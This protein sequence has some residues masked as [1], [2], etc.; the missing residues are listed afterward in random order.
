MKTYID[1]TALKAGCGGYATPN[2]PGTTP[3]GV[4]GIS[5]LAAFDGASSSARI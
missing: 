3:R 5:T 4:D 2:D 1:C